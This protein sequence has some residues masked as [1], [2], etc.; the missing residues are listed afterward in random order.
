MTK[1]ASRTKASNPTHPY[2][3]NNALFQE[4]L[5]LLGKMVQSNL[6]RQIEYLKVENQILRSKFGSRI[7]TT[8]SEKRRL[9]KF[10][11]PLGGAIRDAISIVSYSTFRR[12]VSKGIS[13]GKQP[14]RGRPKKSTQEII[15]LIVRLAKENP[16]WGYGRIMGELKKLEITS[17]SRNTVKAILRNNGIDPS[18]KRGEDTWDAFLKRHFETL[19]ACDFFTKTVW[20]AMGPKIFHVLFFINIR[21]RKVHI[22]GI[23]K[24]PKKEWV[25]T[26][27]KTISFL[28][29][30][31][32]SKA[33]IRDGD[34]KYPEGFD[35]IF[36]KHNTTVKKISY[37]APN[38]NPYCEGWVGTV[39]RECLNH[40][41]VFGETHF[42][43]LVNEY[44][45]YYNTVRPHSSM[46]NLP[47]DYR[48]ENNNGRIGCDSRLGGII[49]HYYRV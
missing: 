35:E 8:A 12:W 49:R 42:K 24:Y 34:K 48:T 37:R 23:T 11:L 29:Q 1:R 36:R 41:F 22:A 4:F 21:T 18:P 9:I 15:N 2:I 3:T 31:D 45:K 38:L 30:D 43:Y 7:T 26:R 46:G 5:T 33:L 27:A 25:T 16:T 39:K 47:L 14:K 19:W 40:F 17:L 20:T 44:V 13:S 28:F 32:K 6:I 10:G